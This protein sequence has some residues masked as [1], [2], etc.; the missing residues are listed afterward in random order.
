MAENDVV[1]A[2]FP[3]SNADNLFKKDVINLGCARKKDT[4]I[5]VSLIIGFGWAKKRK[6][7]GNIG[8]DVLNRRNW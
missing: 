1:I 4:I 6:C 2:I 3:G 8:I 7:P 5:V